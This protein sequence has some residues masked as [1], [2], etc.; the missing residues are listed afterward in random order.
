MQKLSSSS[1]NSHIGGFEGLSAQGSLKDQGVSC[2]NKKYEEMLKFLS[3]Q[4]RKFFDDTFPPG[5]ASLFYSKGLMEKGK[6]IRW[7]RA[8]DIYRGHRLALCNPQDPTTAKRGEFQ[9]LFYMSTC[10]N[11]LGTSPW[12]LERIF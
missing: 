7:M 1:V 2:N 8:E 9:E 3:Y 10:L 4:N 5:G 11:A 12:C 6:E